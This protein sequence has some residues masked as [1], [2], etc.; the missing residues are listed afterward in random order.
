MK[1]KL[2]TSKELT[3]AVIGCAIKVHRLLGSGFL[4]SVYERALALELAKQH[5]SFELQERF[6]VWYS[7]VQV[8]VFAADIVVEDQLI[9]EL[10]AINS[11]TRI[12]EAQLL[13]YLKA[14]GKKIGLILNFGSTTLQIKRIV[15]NYDDYSLSAFS[16]SSA[17]N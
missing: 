10:K 17:A 4:E 15:R 1:D 13:N 16:A 3:E 2:E 5:F 7:G 12:C 8:G 9:L 14:S 11:I 6:E